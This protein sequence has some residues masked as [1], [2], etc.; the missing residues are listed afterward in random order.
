[1]TKKK[2]VLRWSY[3]KYALIMLIILLPMFILTVK[4]QIIPSQNT[5]EIQQTKT[6]IKGIVVDESQQP[7]EGAKVSSTNEETATTDANG[8]FSISADRS[9][10]LEVCHSDRISLNVSLHNYKGQLIVYL[11]QKPK[12]LEIEAKGSRGIKRANNLRTLKPDSRAIPIHQSEW[13]NI[14]AI[15]PGG[16]SALLKFVKESVIYPKKA[17]KAK[18]E[19]RVICSFMINTF[20]QVCNIYLVR[21]VNDELDEEALRVI[22]MLPDWTPANVNGK[23]VCIKYT[24]PVN[25]KLDETPNT[26][27]GL[28]NE[29]FEYEDICE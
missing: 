26:K 25:F 12:S 19:G 7:I 2:N 6:L 29:S 15:Y 10:T 18:M 23:P 9:D 11:Y 22:S 24:L 16:E 28:D 14:Q 27:I 17:K 5:V 20:G 1:M 4:K 13:S 3:L 8:C 21:G